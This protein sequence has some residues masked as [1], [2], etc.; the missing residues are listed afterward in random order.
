MHI[1]AGL[2][3]I[4]GTSL[5]HSCPQFDNLWFATRNCDPSVYD[6]RLL[7][8]TRKIRIGKRTNVVQVNIKSRLREVFYDPFCYSLHLNQSLLARSY[9]NVDKIT[10]N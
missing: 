10:S 1:I 8:H 6:C 5:A 2:V 4:Y 9:V 3:F 7:I